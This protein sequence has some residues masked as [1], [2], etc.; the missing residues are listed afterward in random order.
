MVFLIMFDWRTEMDEH[1]APMKSSFV[2]ED[3]QSEIFPACISLSRASMRFLSDITSSIRL[4]PNLVPMGKSATRSALLCIC[5][6]LTSN[7]ESPVFTMI[8]A[9]GIRPITSPG[10]AT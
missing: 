3:H 4:I 10:V 7:V 9:S 2:G 5:M 8:P 1:F 6:D